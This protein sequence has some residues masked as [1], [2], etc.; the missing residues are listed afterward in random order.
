MNDRE[1][2]E[3]AARA[4][5]IKFEPKWYGVDWNPLTDEGDCYRLEKQLGI[6]IDFHDC[7]AWKR[8]PNGELIQEWWGG[9]CGD[10]AHAIVRVAAEMAKTTEESR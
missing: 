10:E 5:G 3:S 9:E 8:L 6:N 4:A 1:L 7:G 2:L